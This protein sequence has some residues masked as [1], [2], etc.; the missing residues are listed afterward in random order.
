[1]RHD[2]LNHFGWF[3][4]HPTPRLTDLPDFH[5]GTLAYAG[6]AIRPLYF[7]FGPVAGL[8][9]IAYNRTLLATIAVA[10]RPKPRIPILSGVAAP[11]V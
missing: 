1:M 2:S 3:G 5:V 6:A 8:V 7:V 4:W 10:D 11:T 9:A